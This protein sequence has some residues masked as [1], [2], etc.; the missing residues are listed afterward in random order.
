MEARADAAR[1]LSLT[2]RRNAVLQCAASSHV[3][4]G[5]RRVFVCPGR[6][7]LAM[8]AIPQAGIEAFSPGATAVPVTMPPSADHARV[9]RRIRE[10]VSYRVASHLFT[11]KKRSGAALTES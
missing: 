3:N 11:T 6:D 7:A 9:M 4:G 10:S 2:S 5:T 8:M 1:M